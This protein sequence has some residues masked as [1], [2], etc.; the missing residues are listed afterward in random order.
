MERKISARM[1]Y[2]FDRYYLE[3]CEICFYRRRCKKNKESMLFCVL[4]SCFKHEKKEIALTQ[5]R[6]P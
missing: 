6:R 3:K 2:P 5:F 1:N 4:T